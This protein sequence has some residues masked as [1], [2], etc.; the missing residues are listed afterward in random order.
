MARTNGN[1]KLVWRLDRLGRDSAEYIPLL[2]AIKHLGVDV[3]SVT[4][5]TESIFMQEILGVIAEEE[6]RQLSARMTA[7][8][9]RGFKEGKWGNSP[10]L[11]C[12]TKKLSHSG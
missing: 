1:G 11:G 8:Q 6:S 3:V 7:S 10:S 5:P 9:Q 2:K 4:Q 12:A